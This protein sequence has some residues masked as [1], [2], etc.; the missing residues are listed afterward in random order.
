MY[1]LIVCMCLVCVVSLCVFLFFVCVRV[2]WMCVVSASVCKLHMGNILYMITKTM[3]AV[4]MKKFKNEQKSQLFVEQ[5][6]H[7]HCLHFC[8][9][10]SQYRQWWGVA[11]ACRTMEEC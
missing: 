8:T 4:C 1:V 3:L 11:A 9:P 5:Y 7:Y 2:L 10:S 6:L